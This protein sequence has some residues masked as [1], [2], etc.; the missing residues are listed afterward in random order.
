M[1]SNQNSASTSFE[2]GKD[3]GRA[4]QEENI[5][6]QIRHPFRCWLGLKH[7][8]DGPGGE[9]PAVFCSGSVW[10]H[11]QEL[12]GFQRGEI[13]KPHL[14]EIEALQRLEAG[15]VETKHPESAVA[16]MLKE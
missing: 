14:R 13:K 7:P 11:C 9:R 8:L 5:C 10:L 6:I 1:L 3:W 12:W 2:F 16:A 4:F 15:M